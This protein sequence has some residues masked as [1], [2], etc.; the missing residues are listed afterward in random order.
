MS[1]PSARAKR[2]LIPF[3]MFSSL[4]AL[5]STPARAQEH[6]AGH[7]HHG[8]SAAPIGVMGAHVHGRDR[9]M[10][11]YR[12]QYQR[13]DGNMSG[14]ARLSPEDVRADG[15]MAVPTDMD[16]HMHMLGAM[17][18]PIDELTIALMLPVMHMSMHHLTGMPLGAVQFDTDSAG[19]GDMRLAGL[20]RLFDA[21]GHQ[22][23]LG[24]GLVLPTGSTHVRGD[25]PM[26]DQVRL[27]YPMRPGGGSVAANPSLTYTASV[28]IV[29]FGV[30]ASAVLPMHNNEDHYRLG[31]QYRGTAWAGVQPVPWFDTTLRVA[32]LGRENISGADA[33]LNPNMVPTA[34]PERRALFRMDAFLGVGFSAPDTVLSGHRLS[35]EVGMPFYQN[36]SGPQL[37]QLV[38]LMAGWQWTPE[39]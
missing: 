2:A 8:Q 36:V 28:D 35:L 22:L 26:A 30:Q 17:Y 21:P 37:V 25:T 6:A 12:Y 34:D 3:V 32:G 4:I 9:W 14:D 15:F 24:V 39:P 1:R 27:P 20:V 11:S 19:M 18:A 33:D 29:R 16:M 31:F 5:S 10:I 13:M 38:S 23:L 7:S